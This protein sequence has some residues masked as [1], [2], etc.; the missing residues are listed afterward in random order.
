M[1]ESKT[2]ALTLCE[3]FSIPYTEYSIAPYDKIFGSHF[4]DASLTRKGIFAQDYA[5]LFYT[6]IL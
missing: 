3:T 4:K 2:D 5:W 1:P 6:I